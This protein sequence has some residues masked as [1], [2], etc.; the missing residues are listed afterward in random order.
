MSGM[1]APGSAE[2]K[3]HGPF[4]KARR[5]DRAGPAA[6]RAF[7]VTFWDLFGEQ[8]HP[9][10][11]TVAEMGPLAA[12]AAAGTDRGA[13][14]RAERRLPLA[15]EEGLPLLDLARICKALLIFMRAERARAVARY[16][17]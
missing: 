5:D 6:Y 7:P 12:V 8:G 4:M 2:G 17:L 10:R 1:A 9:V 15:D 13:G 16:G 3:L 11:T 14:G